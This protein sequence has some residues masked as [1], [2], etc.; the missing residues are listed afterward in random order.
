MFGRHP[1]FNA[2]AQEWRPATDPEVPSRSCCCP[3]RP[4]VKIIMPSTP[5]RP[6]PVDLWLCDHHYRASQAALLLAGAVV[7]DLT[8]PAADEQKSLA[9]VG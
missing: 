8:T 6:R 3:A 7:E 2:P 5:S 4:I 1:A 9:E